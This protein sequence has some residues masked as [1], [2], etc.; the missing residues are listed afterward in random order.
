[1]LEEQTKTY[2]GAQLVA[3]SKVPERVLEQLAMFGLIAP[4]NGRYSFRDLAAT[5]QIAGLLASGIALSTITKGLSAIRKWLPD[6]HL[7]NL[8][9]FPEASDRILIEQ[10]K[11][12]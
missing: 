10:L 5:R 6:A 8:R 1:L 7:A 2:T 9:V 4:E 3:L 12:R 11:G